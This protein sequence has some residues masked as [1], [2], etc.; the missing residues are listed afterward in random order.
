MRNP[1]GPPAKAAGNPF[2]LDLWDW[3]CPLRIPEG[4]IPPNGIMWVASLLSPTPLSPRRSR[5]SLHS[6]FL[7]F[8]FCLGSLCICFSLTVL[9]AQG[10]DQ[11]AL[12]TLEAGG[13]SGP[14][15][16]KVW[17]FLLIS[18]ELVVE[19]FRSL[20]CTGPTGWCKGQWWCWW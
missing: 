3:V 15:S 1:A 9:D 7:I 12:R 19:C 17:F 8:W 6:R 11:D 18:V 10:P 13:K 2:L 4:S 14:S 16:A 20:M 5:G